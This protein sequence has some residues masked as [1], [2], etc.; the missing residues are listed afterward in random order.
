MLDMT[1]APMLE[2]LSTRF[3]GTSSITSP[4]KGPEPF[5]PGPRLSLLTYLRREHHHPI[6]PV[7]RPLRADQAGLDDVLVAE[8]EA[9]EHE[10]GFRRGARLDPHRRCLR[11][12][13]APLVGL[14]VAV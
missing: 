14:R 4:K 8:D 2:Q 10:L 6:A 12:G 13:V 1:F 3:L 9:F 5:G 11:G 7:A